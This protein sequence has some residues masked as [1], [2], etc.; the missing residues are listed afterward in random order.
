VS[1]TLRRRQVKLPVGQ[2]L[3]RELQI[4]DKLARHPGMKLA[5]MQ[6]IGGCRAVLS[7]GTSDVYGVVERMHQARWDI[8]GEIDD[9]IASPP[10]TAIAR[11]MSWSSATHGL[12]RSSYVRRSSTNGPSRS[13]EPRFSCGCR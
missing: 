11:S 1:P 13:S 3:K 4:I 7:G 6:D 10:L 9:Y 12:S 8:R 2:R 5:R